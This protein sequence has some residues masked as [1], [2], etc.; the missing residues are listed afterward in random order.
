MAKSDSSQIMFAIRLQLY[1]FKLGQA[2]EI[3]LVIAC[4][5]LLLI[6][7]AT[8]FLEVMVRYVL[9]S[10]LSWTEEVA[11]YTLVWFAMLASGVAARRGIHFAFRWG[12]KPFPE[13]VQRRVRQLVNLIVILFLGVLLIQGLNTLSVVA[14][15]TSMATNVDMRVPYAAIPVGMG[16]VLLIY[17]LEVADAVAALWTHRQLSIKEAFDSA[18]QR[19]IGAAADTPVPSVDM[20]P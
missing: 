18:M 2:I 14:N 7:T 13:L 4:S 10:P 15:Q 17:V 19:Q 5:A 3:A 9:N 6:L 1:L 12:M 8:V 11:R 20:F 16:L